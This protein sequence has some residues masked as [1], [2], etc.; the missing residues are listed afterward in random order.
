MH[1]DGMSATAFEQ[2]SFM[3]APSAGPVRHE[4]Q[5]KHEALG[6]FIFDILQPFEI[7]DAPT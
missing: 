4:S 5:S 2:P 6:S 7:T 1:D 3:G